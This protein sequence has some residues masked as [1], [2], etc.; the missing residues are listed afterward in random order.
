MRSL[1]LATSVLV[2]G[3]TI[4]NAQQH[5]DQGHE[6]D[7]VHSHRGPGPHFI[8]AFFTENAFI[9]RKLRPDIFISDG[10]EGQVYTAQLEVEWA[11]IPNL[12]IVTHIPFHHLSPEV[13]SSESGIGDIGIGPKL[14]VVN[15]RQRFI[16]AVGGDFDIPTG[17]ADRGLGEEHAAFAPFLLA[18]LPF[19]PERRWTLQTAGHL[20]IPLTSEPESEHVELSTALSWTSPLGL[21]PIVEGIVE[22]ATEGGPATWFVAPEFRLE[23]GGGFEVGA[24]VRIPVSGPRED[25]YRLAVGLIRHFPLPR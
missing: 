22:F 3:V 23:V 15:D 10:D 21:T 20:E 24:G 7:E 18:W 2:G 4:A 8:D 11:L 14:A 12:S 5:D 9:E 25:D 1:V 13:G 17:D 16:L 19:G 6:H